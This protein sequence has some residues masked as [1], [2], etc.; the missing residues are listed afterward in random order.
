MFLLFNIVGRLFSSF[1]SGT[2]FYWDEYGV[3][4]DLLITYSLQYFMSLVDINSPPQ[5]DQTDLIGLSASFSTI[6]L[7]LLNTS[8]TSNFSFKK[9]TQ[10]FPRVHSTHI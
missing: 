4:R 3:A 9:Y 8:N 10:G 7:N 5:L 2:L 1:F 6:I